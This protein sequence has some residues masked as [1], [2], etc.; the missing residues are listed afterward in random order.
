MYD[1]AVSAIITAEEAERKVRENEIDR[2]N[3]ESQINVDQT[4]DSESTEGSV[5]RRVSKHTVKQSP[6][7]DEDEEKET[8]KIIEKQ[9][10]PEEGQ[11]SSQQQDASAQQAVAVQQM[12]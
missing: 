12:Q 11:K 9:S 2:K 3:A 1:S 10:N 4:Q 6:K 5:V 7:E 8:T